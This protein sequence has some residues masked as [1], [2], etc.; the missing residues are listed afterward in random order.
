MIFRGVHFRLWPTKCW[1]ACNRA[2]TLPGICYF[3]KRSQNTWMLIYLI[4][5]GKVKTPVP[6]IRE[7]YSYGRISNKKE[8]SDES[9]FFNLYL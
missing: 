5:E 6:F 8:P 9:S 2:P 3:R 7:V 1:K 4:S